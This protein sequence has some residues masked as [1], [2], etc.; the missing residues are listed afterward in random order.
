MT[1]Q[2]PKSGWGTGVVVVFAVFVA[3]ML[4]VTV[5][6]MTKDVDLVNDRYYEQE[7]KYQERIMAQERVHAS[8]K[9]VGVEVR[10]GGII[11]QLPSIA[12]PGETVGHVR[13]YRPSNGSAD[14]AF[15][16]LLDTLW[17]QRIPAAEFAPGLWR[18]QAQWTVRG[19]EYYYEQPVMLP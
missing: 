2:R 9:P 4:T 1:A 7:V 6:L 14:R 11:I 16:L 10:P 17:Q 5:T 18:V 15:A 12:T 3:A 13:L 8:G 19:E